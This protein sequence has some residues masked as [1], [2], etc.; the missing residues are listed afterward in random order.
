MAGPKITKKD[1]G[2]KN[3]AP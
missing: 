3:K 2:N 1:N